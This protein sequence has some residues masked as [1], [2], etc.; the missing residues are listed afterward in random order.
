M[1][2]PCRGGAREVGRAMSSPGRPALVASVAMAAAGAGGWAWFLSQYPLADVGA[3]SIALQ[4][5]FSL[6]TV[7]LLVIA[8]LTLRASR[9]EEPRPENKGSAVTFNNNNMVKNRIIIRQDGNGNRNPPD[10]GA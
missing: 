3:W 1:I 9:S 2:F 10:G 7:P 4:G 8:W 6:L 5:F